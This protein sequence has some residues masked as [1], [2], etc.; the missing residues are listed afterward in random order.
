MKK[1]LEYYLKLNY[2]IEITAIDEA[3]GGGFFASVPLLRGCMSDGETIDEA[4]QNISDA[5]A[6]WLANMLERKMPIP[7]PYADEAFSGKFVV[8]VPKSL[9]R[10]LAEESEKEGISL[11]QFIT[12]SLSYVMGKKHAV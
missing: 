7:E 4:Y 12:N 2:P 5:K 6:E 11:N 8:R 10:L 9:H 3:D 1:D